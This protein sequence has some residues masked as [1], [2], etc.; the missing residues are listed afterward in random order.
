MLSLEIK[1]LLDGSS[2]GCSSTE[3]FNLLLMGDKRFNLAKK[4]KLSD[5]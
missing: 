5:S 1:G 4:I 2:G 3:E